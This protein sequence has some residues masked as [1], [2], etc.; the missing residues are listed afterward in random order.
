MGLTKDHCIGG[1]HS[2]RHLCSP[3]SHYI[4][5]QHTAM[6]TLDSKED[7]KK[8]IRKV[9]APS[10]ASSTSGIQQQCIWHSLSSKSCSANLD[11]HSWEDT[12]VS[13]LTQSVCWSVNL[14]VAALWHTWIQL[15]LLPQHYTGIDRLNI[16]Q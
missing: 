11:I 4:L 15:N 2:G 6:V 9:I 16:L 13:F 3:N 1:S 10:L 7:F 5:G 14:G 12:Q 8:H